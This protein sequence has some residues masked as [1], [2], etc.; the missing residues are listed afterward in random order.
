MNISKISGDPNL[1]IFQFANVKAWQ[2]RQ[3]SLRRSVET[4]NS[5]PNISHIMYSHVICSAIRLVDSM[6]VHTELDMHIGVHR[7][8][9]RVYKVPVFT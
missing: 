9:S 7:P 4:I 2:K 6:Y 1:C 8:L 5:C 3:N